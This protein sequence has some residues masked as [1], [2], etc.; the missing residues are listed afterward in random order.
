MMSVVMSRVV[1]TPIC[2]EA[3]I[4]SFRFR[5]LAEVG[6]RQSVYINLSSTLKSRDLSKSNQIK[7]EPEVDRTRGNCLLQ[8][9]IYELSS[10]HKPYEAPTGAPP[11]LWLCL[12][13]LSNPIAYH[14]FRYL[15]LLA[16][17]VS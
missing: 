12:C 15:I 6:S 5:C 17:A 2:L 11:T 1:V 14:L 7:A 16:D 10:P 8:R 9:K 4:F 3:T 13:H